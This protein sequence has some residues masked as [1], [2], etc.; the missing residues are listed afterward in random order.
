MNCAIA[1]RRTPNED[2]EGIKELWARFLVNYSALK[3][4][5]MDLDENKY[6]FLNIPG[7]SQYQSFINLFSL[8]KGEEEFFGELLLNNESNIF[9]TYHLMD[10]KNLMTTPILD[11]L[12]NL[13]SSAYDAKGKNIVMSS[14]SFWKQISHT[15][16]EAV[17]SF[18]GL[19]KKGA[20]V[21]IYTQA[22]KNERYIKDI[23]LPIKEASRFGL[24]NRIPMHFLKADMDYAQ[25]E[26]PHTESTMFRLTMFLDFQ[27]LEPKLKEGRTRK[28]LSDFFDKM[29]KEAM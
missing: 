4:G 22:K 7:P 12:G 6:R 25:P 11:F 9:Y 3:N 18:E 20:S 2:W 16:V 19:Y 23:M 26:M 28:D 8:F 15:R 1:P 13:N 29:V 5:E 10:P 14:G 17:S 24:N 21:N 27:K